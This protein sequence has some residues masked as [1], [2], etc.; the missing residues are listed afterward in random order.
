VTS[1]TIHSRGVSNMLRLSTI[2]RWQIVET[3]KP[4]SVAEHSYRTWVLARDLYGHMTQIN[5]NSFEHDGV[6]MWALEHDLDEVQ[7]GDL[8][9]TVKDVL[10]E[11]SPGITKQLKERLLHDARLTSVA[12]RMRGLANTYAAIVVKIADIAESI[13]FIS[14]YALNPAEGLLVRAY[15]Q[16]KLLDVLADAEKRYPVAEWRRAREWLE[17]LLTNETGHWP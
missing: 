8:P 5:H 2:S 9:S 4:Q 16:G 1:S 11:I 10:E 3:L 13:I 7:S 12:G 15:L 14:R 6:L 17:E